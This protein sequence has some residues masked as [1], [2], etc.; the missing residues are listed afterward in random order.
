MKSLWFALATVVGACGHPAPVGVPTNVATTGPAI[1][2]ER[3]EPLGWIAIGTL[4][5]NDSS[6]I[7]V[8]AD[9]GVITITDDP[10]PPRVTVIGARGGAEQLTVGAS[11]PLKYGCDDNQLGVHPLTGVRLPPG[12]AWILPT[13]MPPAWRPT[14]LPVRSTHGDP[15]LRA[16]IAGSL[17]FEMRRHGSSH[18]NLVITHDGRKAFEATYERS[19]MDGADTTGPIDLTETVPG[20]P[21]PIAAWSLSPA[22]PFLVVMLHPGYEG[23]TLQPMLVEDNSARVL[24]DMA[25][26]LYSCA[27]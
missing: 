6:W 7:P 11:V 16:H 14:A 25:V 27:F 21:E 13:P 22:G 9:L 18:A 17:V 23:V 24:E 8:S 26:Y 1:H 15:T 12:P 10:L 3:G 2:L 19:E 20:I 5:A 4:P